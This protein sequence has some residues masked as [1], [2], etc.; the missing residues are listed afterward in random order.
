MS[1]W[2]YENWTAHKMM[3]RFIPVK[4]Q[5]DSGFTGCFILIKT[6]LN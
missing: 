5:I 3:L 4:N 6:I 1:Y 2:V